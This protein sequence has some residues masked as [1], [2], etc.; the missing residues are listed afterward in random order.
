MACCCSNTYQFC[1]KVNHCSITDLA[2]L[3]TGLSD[4]SYFI[5][6]EF[7]STEIVRQMT[8]TTT[9]GIRTTTIETIDLNECYEYVGQLI[10]Q[11]TGDIVNLVKDGINYDCFTFKTY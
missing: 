8:I 2:G 6:L 4:G 9:D 7:L 11:A 5:K 1:K 3:F 10:N